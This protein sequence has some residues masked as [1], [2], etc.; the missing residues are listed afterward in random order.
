MSSIAKMRFNQRHYNYPYQTDISCW[1][2][3]IFEEQKNP[4]CAARVLH[5]AV[6]YPSWVLNGPYDAVIWGIRNG[7]TI[8]ESELVGAIVIVKDSN[9][10]RNP[11]Q[12]ERRHGAGSMDVTID[13]ASHPD[14]WE[15][16]FGLR[17]A[18]DPYTWLG[19]GMAGWGDDA[20]RAATL[21]HDS[22]RDT[23]S[24]DDCL[25]VHRDFEKLLQM[26]RSSPKP[27]RACEDLMPQRE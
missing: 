14:R 9:D 16:E 21:A 2:G 22:A 10:R 5:T 23:A 20:A 27:L 18:L 24:I 8:S 3:G 1:S 19:L 12:Y 17:M 11:L 4:N 25:R 7:T 26:N 13:P 6:A 15:A